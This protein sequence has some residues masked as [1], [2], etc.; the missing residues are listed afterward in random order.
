MRRKLKVNVGKSKVMMSGKSQ[1]GEQL[2][3]IDAFKYL[4]ANVGKNGGVL[5]LAVLLNRVNKGAKVVGAMSRI[6]RVR[7]LGINVKRM[8]NESIA[9]SAVWGREKRRF[10]VMK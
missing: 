5:V 10:N 7:S 8:M 2:E 4:G 9:D 3:E 1:R 6:W